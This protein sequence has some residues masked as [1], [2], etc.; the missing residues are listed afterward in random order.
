MQSID[1]NLDAGEDP[2]A[3]ADGSE[4]A[5][6]DL[7]TSVNIAC[8][9]HAGTNATMTAAVR[10]AKARG[11]SIGAHPSY[12]DRP[13][14]GRTRM[15]IATGNLV[16]SLTTQI[17]SL[18]TVCAKNGVVLSHVKPHGALYHAVAF[19]KESASAF[20]AA[21]KNVDPKLRIVG[22]AG[23]SFLEW[24]R[25]AG[26]D[27][28]GEAFVD[29]LYEEDGRLRSR[30]K[31]GAVI[32]DP[33]AAARQALL[34]ARDGVVVCATGTELPLQARTLCIHGDT[35]GAL[36]VARAVRQAL[37]DGGIKP[38]GLR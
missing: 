36:T 12:P 37:E 1:L 5:L 10:W 19:E 30:E 34:I 13:G 18:V 22:F 38:E 6:Y 32:T 2:N 31:L 25:D 33:E 14:F 24:C 35:P 17:Q 27:A 8:G 15:T 26:C 20:I 28:V 23:S 7:V 21:V 3:L 29:R 11:I 4:I 16:H 9:G